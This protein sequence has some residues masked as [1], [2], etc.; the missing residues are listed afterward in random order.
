MAH[1]TRYTLRCARPPRTVAV[2]ATAAAAAGLALTVLPCRLPSV[3]SEAICCD[4]RGQGRRLRAPRR[5]TLG[6]PNL[7]YSTQPARCRAGLPAVAVQCRAR[8]PAHRRRFSAGPISQAMS[9]SHEDP[10]TP[11]LQTTTPARHVSAPSPLAHGGWLR[12]L[13]LWPCR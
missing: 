7:W 13:E 4:A 1:P 5:R 9:I 12:S 6:A 8:A 2:A 3:Y 11:K 10:G